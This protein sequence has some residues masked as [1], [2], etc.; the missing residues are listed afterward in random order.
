MR[1][2][3]VTRRTRLPLPGPGRDLLTGIRSKHT[4]QKGT[5]L[6]GSPDPPLRAVCLP[7]F[8]SGFHLGHYCCVNSMNYW[9]DLLVPQ[10]QI[11]NQFL[12]LESASHL[13]EEALE[14]KSVFGRKYL[15]LFA[16][17]SGRMYGI[18]SAEIRNDLQN[19][20]CKSD[21]LSSPICNS[22]IIFLE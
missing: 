1:I 15:F 16:S 17:S 8:A 5:L 10:D 18:L 9:Q 6:I 20:G 13:Y 2:P 14:Y 11:G 19:Y 4:A 21:N 7:V 22:R 12:P 3:S